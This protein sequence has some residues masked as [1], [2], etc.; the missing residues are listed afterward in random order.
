MNVSAVH[1]LS[2]NSDTLYLFYRNH[3]LNTGELQYNVQISGDNGIT[4]KKSA[5]IIEEAFYTNLLDSNFLYA[6]DWVYRRQG[7]MYY[8]FN[9]IF[10]APIDSEYLGNYFYPISYLDQNGGKNVIVEN[11]QHKSFFIGKD[12]VTS[13]NMDEIRNNDKLMN[14]NLSINPN[15]FNNSVIISFTLPK[16]GRVNIT[17]FDVNGSKV[18]EIQ[19]YNANSGENKINFEANKL[20]SGVYFVVLRYN[21]LTY[22]TKALLVK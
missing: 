18:K 6:I 7:I 12:I 16:D 3:F 22:S 19:S 8:K 5:N 9:D 20:A 13:V 4:F 11:S 21:N 14:I 17:L 2:L 1:I 15:P 10:S